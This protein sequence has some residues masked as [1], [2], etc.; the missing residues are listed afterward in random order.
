MGLI[1]KEWEVSNLTNIANYQNGLAM[2]KFP[3]ENDAD[4]FKVLKI[5]E[6]GKVL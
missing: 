3:P 6:Y 4:C 1:P 5:K 2:Q